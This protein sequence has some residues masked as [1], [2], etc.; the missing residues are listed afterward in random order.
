ME[1]LN[2][3][4]EEIME[5]TAVDNAIAEEKDAIE[6]ENADSPEESSESVNLE[7][8]NISCLVTNENASTTNCLA[9]TIQ[10][11]HKIVAIKNVFWRSIR[12]SWK[13][14]VSTITLA[15]IK[16]FS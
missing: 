4:N 7:S 3:K 9:L 12:M 5:N 16:L 15:L 1:T 8:T 11:E 10:K 13:V 14:A 6:K 2:E